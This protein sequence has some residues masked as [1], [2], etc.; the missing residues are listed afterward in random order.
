MA[1]ILKLNV[2]VAVDDD[3]A[4]TAAN[5]AAEMA[6]GDIGHN[7]AQSLQDRFAEQGRSTR[8]Q[9]CGAVDS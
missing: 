5:V 7:L 1:K 6:S 3:A 4:V 8:V 2:F 9:Y